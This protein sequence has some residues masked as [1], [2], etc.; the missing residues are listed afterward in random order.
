MNAL[1]RLCHM[2][3]VTPFEKKRRAAHWNPSVLT[4]SHVSKINGKTY[5]IREKN[6]RTEPKTL[7]VKLAA[8]RQAKEKIGVISLL[9]L[10]KSLYFDKGEILFL[11][12]FPEAFVKLR[13]IKARFCMSPRTQR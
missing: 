3:P 10:S 4:S 2:P 5:G 13:R 1:D 7:G 6:I 9:T 8:K 11:T 12:F